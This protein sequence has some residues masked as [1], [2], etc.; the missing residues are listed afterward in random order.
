M[1][2]TLIGY[3]GSGK[4]RVAE[5]LAE[6]LGWECIDADTEIERRAG[7]SIRDIFATQGEPEFR[8]QERA[9]M[10]DVQQRDRIVVAAG[11]GA[12]LDETTRRELPACGPVV[13][14]RA[15]PETLRH[16]ITSDPTTSQRRP[17]LTG[18]D[19]QREIE[20]LLAERTPL[21]RECATFVID[22][23]ATGV[24]DIVETILAKL[25]ARLQVDG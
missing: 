17:K 4:S 25:P 14:L 19:A 23:D 5:A 1:I 2:I 6:R 15:R 8:R 13:W 11:G 22:T 3:R 12:I 9:V 16:R 7:Q 20:H 10:I 24:D 21:Y 18:H